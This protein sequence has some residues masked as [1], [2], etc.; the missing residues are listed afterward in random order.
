MLTFYL[1]SNYSKH[2][3][4]SIDPVIIELIIKINL[5]RNINVKTNNNLCFLEIDSSNY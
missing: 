2:V 3:L 4:Q 1:Q 5:V